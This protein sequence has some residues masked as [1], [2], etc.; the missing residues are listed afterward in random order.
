MSARSTDP[1]ALR[2]VA[3][4][5]LTAALAVTAHGAAGATVPGAA[6]A[7]LLLASA[8]VGGLAGSVRRAGEP[9]VLVGVLA[10]GQVLGH[11]ILAAAGHVH[12]GSPSGAMLSAH[13]VAVVAGGLLLAG[14]ERLYRTLSSVLQAPGGRPSCPPMVRQPL[15]PGRADHP[16]QSRLIVAVSISHRGPPAWR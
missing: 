13:L 1:A 15:A 6:L 9:A 14:A 3:V 12:G 2:G 16:L 8:G 5:S 7:L 11:V 10:L 4:G